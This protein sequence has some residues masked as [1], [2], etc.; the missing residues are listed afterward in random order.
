MNMQKFKNALKANSKN[1]V[2]AALA[3]FVLL[4]GIKCAA[5]SNGI[6]QDREAIKSLMRAAAWD[7]SDSISGGM[8]SDKFSEALYRFDSYAKALSSGNCMVLS[9]VLLPLASEDKF[10]SLTYEERQFISESI[11]HLFF[12]FEIL[13][14]PYEELSPLIEC[15]NSRSGAIEFSE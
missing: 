14:L 12:A 11:T 10:R 6:K 4:L 2:I 5:Q 3:V 8:Y 13:E 15:I 9:R 1:I 7:I